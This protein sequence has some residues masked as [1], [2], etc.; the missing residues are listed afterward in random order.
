M[1][2]THIES[3]TIQITGNYVNGEDMLAFTN[4]A[5]ITG[6]WNAVSGTMTLSGSDTLTNYR[7]ALKAVTYRN[8]SNDPSTLVRTVSFTVNDGDDVSDPVTRDV[9]ITA[10]N[11]A[12]VISAPATATAVEETPLVFS[13]A[14]GN[15]IIINDIDAGA[16]I[17]DV[18]V[19][20]LNGKATL[21]GTTG[22]FSHSGDGTGSISLRG[23]LTSVNDALDGLSFV[24]AVDFD[25]TTRIDIYV[26]D[27]G[28]TGTVYEN[29]EDSHTIDITIT[30][31]NDDP[32]TSSDNY[33]ID[34]D[35]T[36]SV[37]APGVLANDSDPDSTDPNFITEFG[38]PGASDGQFAN[39]GGIEFDSS[40]NFF[41]VDTNNDRI[42]IFDSDGNYLMQFGSTG[43]GN[44]EF[45]SPCDL[46]I[47]SGGNIYVADNNNDRIQKFDSS[48]NHLLTWGVNGSGNG[49]FDTPISLAVDSTDNV[50]VVDAWNSRVQKFDS[51]G[52]YLQSWGS[53]GT[54]DGQF[55][56]PVSIS[57]D[58]N[59]TV[60]V[61]ES[62]GDRIQQ[63]D[64][65]GNHL[66][67]FGSGGADIGEINNPSAIAFDSEG[68]A[69]ISDNFNHRVQVFDPAGNYIMDWGTEGTAAGQFQHPHGI[70][71][72]ATGRVWV[73]DANNNR[74]QIFA[75]PE[76]SGEPLTAALVSG[77]GHASS[78][79]L[80][81]DGSFTYTPAANWNGTDTFVYEANDGNGGVA[82]ETVAINVTPVND[83][84]SVTT[85]GTT[86]AY[87][88]GDVATAIDPGLILSDVDSHTWPAQQ[89]VSSSGFS[90]GEDVLAFTN[91]LGI[92]GSYNAT[93]GILALT[94]SASVAD[95]QMALRIGDL[96][97]HQRDAVDHEPSYHF[98]VSDGTVTSYFDSNRVRSIDQRRP[99]HNVPLPTD[100]TVI[101]G[102]SS[103]VDLSAVDFSDLD[104]DNQLLTVTLT[105]STGGRLYAWT[106]MDVIVSGSGGSI[107]TLQG[108]LANL[109]SFFNSP[110]H[111][112]YLH[113]NT[114]LAGDNADTI[115]V[116]IRD[117]GN[118]G[119]GGGGNI[120]LGTVNVD[121][122][123]VN[124]APVITSN[125]GG[126]T[127]SVNV[128][129]NTTAVTTVTAT[130]AD[131]GDTLT[132][133]IDPA[134]ADA[135]K[136]SIDANSGVL[137][138]N[139]APDFEVPTDTGGNNVYDVTVKVDDGNG[140]TDTQA[141]SVNVTD[142]SSTLVVTTTANTN[143]GDVSSPEALNVSKGSDGVISLME[144]ITAANN[145]SEPIT[146]NFNISEPLV[147]GAHTIAISPGGLPAITNTI[148]IDGTTDPD[149]A[150]APVIELDGSAAGTDVDGFHISAGGS[151]SRIQGLVINRFTGNYG[152]SIEL[153]SASNVTI[154]GN[155]IG[156]DVAGTSALGMTAYGAIH[157]NNADGNTISNNVVS[158]NDKSGIWLLNSDNNIVQNN[159]IGTDPSGMLNVGNQGSGI[160]IN[161]GSTGNLIGGVNDGE[162]NV[163]AF[164][165]SEGIT[166]SVSGTNNAILRN[167][168]FSNTGIPVDLKDDSGVTLN[169]QG[170]GDG[171]TNNLQNFPVLDSAVTDESGSLAITG[172][173]NSNASK[174]YRIEFFANNTEDVSGHGEAE[175]FIDAITVTTDASGDIAFSETLSAMVTAGEYITATATVDLGSDTYGDTSEF[176]ANIQAVGP[177]APPTVAINTGTSVTVGATVLIRNTM[178]NEGD[179]DDSGIGLTYTLT[180]TSVNGTLK[181]SGADLAL[182]DTFTQA[183]IDLNRITYVHDG[184][185]S[186][187]D[188]FDFSLADG[189]EDGSTPATG[190]FNI[191]VMHPP[192][193]AVTTGSLSYTENDG[194]VLIDSGVTISDVDS[195]TMNLA[196]VQ[197]TTGF[198]SGEDVL[199]FTSQPGITGSYNSG[200]GI[201]I[202]NGV[203]SV[204]DYQ[205]VLQS[206]TYENTSENP[207]T[208]DRTLMIYVRDSSNTTD[209]ETLTLSVT[210]LNDAPTL[211]AAGTPTLTA[212]NE[213]DTNPMGNTVASIVIDGSITDPDGSPVEAIA[214]IGVNNINGTWEYSLNDGADWNAFGTPLSSAARLLGPTDMVRFVPNADFNGPVNPGLTFRA[215]D[216]S[217]GS[218]G[219]VV[220][221]MTSG[222]TTP[223]S[224]NSDV[225]TITVNAVND[226]PTATIVASAFGVTEDDGYRLFGGISV[227][228]ADVG[229]NELAVTLSVN[230]GLI[231]L[232]NTTGLTFTIG[233]NNSASMTFTGPATDLNTALGSFT[234]RPGCRFCRYRY[235][236]PVRRRPG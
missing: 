28:N 124:D 85:T 21:A 235:P 228:D 204:A 138:F 6:N 102:V 198:V 226:A 60:W 83:A 120:D 65:S 225:A 52:T 216:Q 137:T 170:D 92:T 191:T 121:I 156:T 113:S 231:N 57:I 140:G 51:T 29:L 163:I 111:I 182:N 223:Y 84:P 34:E 32:V 155:Y 203:A 210:A 116:Q 11:D 98:R 142:V 74:I 9:N 158:G 125:G 7:D 195:A 215:W 15:P 178:L 159:L 89:C 110:T 193:I 218:A 211:S 115:Q 196:Y 162:G 48:G 174:T 151:G 68:N 26:M 175:R 13:V 232:T 80:N 27:F 66:L 77:P 42:Q 70:A 18:S 189:G 177:N 181:L 150:G 143:D 107:I 105:T 122:T 8:T 88:E 224:S 197:I 49:E 184:S 1:D 3:A 131:T 36:L 147:N 201:L 76:S 183:D 119:S 146:I 43:T 234:Y 58:A 14:N 101:E 153:D 208:S 233:A 168:F 123:N 109:N 45:D 16:G 171:G 67:T 213:D 127:A 86:L 190:T 209:T 44:G 169:D 152:S 10:V 135:D 56:M 141:I 59:D 187:S 179:P 38:S 47:D 136:F 130:D 167:T 20:V 157:L 4:T 53:Y 202:L 50:Y 165:D 96:S 180:G 35:A 5:A 108:G 200:T 219:D 161:S 33:T 93:T 17:V 63:F 41:V 99:D 79:T 71:V 145:S 194:P 154:T 164:N 144:A 205:A 236:D 46:A 23:D 206:V 230:N 221:T 106:D 90:T 39:P 72:D 222:G 31:V 112:Q 176:A 40:G 199:S 73:A 30:P 2:D 192:T 87:T 25:E 97:K 94:G 149:Y 214:V 148:I 22:L 229:A 212:V 69:Y 82:Q 207:N 24:G 104:H 134:S 19:V 188:S 61:G 12:P 55:N 54:A 95:Y 166:F 185:A 186:V 75:E 126:A 64:T 91:Q 133:S 118:T 217:S 129:E 172:K 227:S 62:S 173:L 139:T 128:V 103:G 100:V 114:N 81:A 78:F 117:N 132:Y 37:I 220:D 160:Y